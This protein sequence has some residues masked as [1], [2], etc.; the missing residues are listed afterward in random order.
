MQ[1]CE[2][3]FQQ[4]LIVYKTFTV[5]LKTKDLQKSRTDLGCGNFIKVFYK[6]TT[7]SR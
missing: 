5:G 2:S 3:L 6:T 4:I 1:N 7:C